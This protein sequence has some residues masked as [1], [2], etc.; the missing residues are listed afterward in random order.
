QRFVDGKTE[1]YPLPG[2][3]HKFAARRILRDRDGGLWIGTYTDGLLHLH[4]GRTDQFSL[5]DGLS[6]E[7]IGALLEDGEGNIWATTN[8]GL[9]RFRDYSIPT[10]SVKQGMSATIVGSVLADRAGSVWLATYGGF[11]HWDKGQI[12]IPETGSIKRDGKLR[13]RAPNSLFQ[14]DRGR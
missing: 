10:F 3:L 14:D 13:G 8:G 11:N 4:Q 6:A 2:F 12:T 7:D 1:S 9:D 5:S